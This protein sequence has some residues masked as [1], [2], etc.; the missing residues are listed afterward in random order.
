M[1]VTINGHDLNVETIAALIREVPR[2]T[3]GRTISIST[4]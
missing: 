1:I 2:L 3:T 4:N